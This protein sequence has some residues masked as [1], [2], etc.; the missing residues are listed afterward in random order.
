MVSC[1]SIDPYTEFEVIIIGAGI[2]EITLA[3]SKAALVDERYMD[4]RLQ[5]IFRFLSRFDRT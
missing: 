4:N 5:S 3:F 2:P 1:C